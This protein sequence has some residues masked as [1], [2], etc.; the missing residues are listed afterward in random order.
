MNKHLLNIIKEYVSYKRIFINE[1]EYQTKGINSGLDMTKNL[2]GIKIKM[3]NK[4]WYLDYCGYD[5]STTIITTNTNVIR[6]YS[7]MNSLYYN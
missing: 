2:T 1:L 5:V 3:R 4:Y 7:G 6:M